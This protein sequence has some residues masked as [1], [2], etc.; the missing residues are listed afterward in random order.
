MR[1]RA[2]WVQRDYADNVRRTMKTLAHHEQTSVE[3]RAASRAHAHSVFQPH[4]SRTAAEV[5]WAKLR[6]AVRTG[7]GGV[8]DTGVAED[9]GNTGKGEAKETAEAHAETKL[10][11]PRRVKEGG[12][13]EGKMGSPTKAKT[14]PRLM[15]SHSFAAAR[16]W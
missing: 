3:N 5:R 13:V 14:R 12:G 1:R 4:H 8:G 6:D 15:H 7:A 2:A 11:S 10:R 16:N 9:T